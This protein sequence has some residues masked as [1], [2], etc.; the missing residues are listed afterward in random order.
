MVY[1]T[2]ELLKNKSGDIIGVPHRVNGV[3]EIVKIEKNH[4]VA[5]VTNHTGNLKR[6]TKLLLTR[7]DLLI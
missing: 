4:A 5:K 3:V 6:A 2:L 7:K 1:T